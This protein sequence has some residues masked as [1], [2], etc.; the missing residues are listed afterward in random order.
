VVGGS[1]LNGK[2]SIALSRPM[3]YHPE[4]Q[5]GIAEITM[6]LETLW[7]HVETVANAWS[8]GRVG[9]DWLPAHRRARSIF[10]AA[11]GGSRRVSSSGYFAT[12]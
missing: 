7:P 9:P 11:S 8:E 5:H 3:I 4:V 12:G 10:R 6:E 1:R 2:R